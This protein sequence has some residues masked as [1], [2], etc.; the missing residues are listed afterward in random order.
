MRIFFLRL[1]LIIFGTVFQFSFLNIFFSEKYPVNLILFFLVSWT[2]LVDFDKIWKWILFFGITVDVF[3]F[4]FIGLSAVLFLVVAY[5]VDMVSKN[6]ISKD[7]LSWL[8]FGVIIV[9]VSVFGETIFYKLS[10]EFSNQGFLMEKISFFV[11]VK[12]FFNRLVLN[13]AVFV[14]IF[15][16]VKFIENKIYIFEKRKYQNV[17]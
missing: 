2:M 1:S 12:L 14:V 3:C 4:N 13:L 6:F 17:I 8:F 11:L 9:V 10:I 15:N 5:C 16:I 7:D